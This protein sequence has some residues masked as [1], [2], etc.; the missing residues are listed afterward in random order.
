M[1]FMSSADSSVNGEV[2][3]IFPQIIYV[4]TKGFIEI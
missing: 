3:A 1:G 4:H 2:T